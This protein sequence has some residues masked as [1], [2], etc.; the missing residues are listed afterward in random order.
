MNEA[1]LQRKVD[2]LNDWRIELQHERSDILLAL[3]CKDDPAWIAK[4][5]RLLR[6]AAQRIL[7]QGALN[8]SP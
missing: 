7:G 8:G 5:G 2:E 3:R 6:P 1:T 4:Y